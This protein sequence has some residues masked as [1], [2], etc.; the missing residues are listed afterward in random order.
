[1]TSWKKR[2]ETL[3]A[4]LGATLETTDSEVNCVAPAGFTWEPDSVH[5]LVNSPWG[6]ETQTAMYRDA[7]KRMQAQELR[8]C[9]PGCYCAGR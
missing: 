5:A 9:P 8:P 6:D 3:A 2:A 1:M 4:K 7:W